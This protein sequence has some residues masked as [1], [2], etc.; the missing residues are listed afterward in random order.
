MDDFEA[1]S[2]WY[3]VAFFAIS[4][5]VLLLGRRRFTPGDLA[6]VRM[7]VLAPPETERLQ[8]AVARR[9]ALESF[10]SAAMATGIALAA[11]IAAVLGALT[12]APIS[13]LFAMLC[14]VLAGTVAYGYIR[15]RRAGTRRVASLRARHQSSAIAP[16]MM[17]A[18]VV[19][20][21]SPLVFIDAAP[22]PAIVVT[23]ASVAIAL[24][25][26][27]VAQLPALL[28]GVDPQVEA[29]LDD[30]VRALRSVNLVGLATAPAYVFESTL[31]IGA[32]GASWPHAIAWIA[33]TFAAFAASISQIATIKRRPDA[34]EIAR[35]GQTGG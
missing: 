11:L 5:I 4:G 26:V 23:A 8:A 29:Y 31:T 16:W 6:L 28:S 20:A 9:D 18:A 7:P 34:S 15:L 32:H 1:W 21:V 25:G 33:V 27:R 3:W 14:L 22:L 2:R 30:R 12:S 13:L 10:P 24:V 17:T 35:W 19:A